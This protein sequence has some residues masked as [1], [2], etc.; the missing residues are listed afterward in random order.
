ME[1]IPMEKVSVVSC[2]SYQQ[3]T[4]YLA[5][6]KTIADIGFSLPENKKI[7]LNLP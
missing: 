3:E 2:P 1:E 6:K 7:L 4:V 5:L